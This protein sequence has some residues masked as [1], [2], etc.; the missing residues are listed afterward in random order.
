[1]DEVLE[2]GVTLNTIIFVSMGIEQVE[3]GNL[4]APPD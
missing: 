4:T 3:R 2:V 1:V